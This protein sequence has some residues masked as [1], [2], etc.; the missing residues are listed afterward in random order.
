MTLLSLLAL[1]HTAPVPQPDENPVEVISNS[2]SPASANSAGNANSNTGL[3]DGADITLK[4]DAQS[5]A[6]N[7]LSPFS[8][9]VAGNDNENTGTLD[10]TFDGNTISIPVD[11][12]P[13]VNL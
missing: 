8:D 12:E 9:S 7:G 10:G 6:T 4:R 2:V 1:S 13:T 5:D 11:I 3:L